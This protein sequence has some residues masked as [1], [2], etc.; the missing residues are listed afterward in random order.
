MKLSDIRNKKVLVKC[1]FNI[2]NLESLE[3]IEAAAATIGQLIAQKNRLILLTHW[4]RPNGVPDPEWSTRKLEP[5]VQK[6]LDRNSIPGMVCWIDQWKD[7]NTFTALKKS[8]T[9][10]PPDCVSLME[11]TRFSPAEESDVA[12]E[13]VAL[14][15]RYASIAD[16]VV[17][18]A[19]SLSH[20]QE[21]TNYDL[22]Q[23]LPTV[24][25]LNYERE[26]TML[27]QV[28]D[29]PHHPLVFVLGGAKLETKLELIGKA[30][31]KADRVLIGGQLCFT[32]LAAAQQLGLAQYRQVDI[33]GSLVEQSF[34]PQ[35]ISLLQQY[36]DKIV[37]PVDFV[38]DTEE[39]IGRYGA[40]IG[41]ETIVLFGRALSNAKTVFWN[42][43]MGR[44]EKQPYD[45]GTR[46][47]AGFL[48]EK[49]H[50]CFVCVGGGD[51]VAGLPPEMV[52]QFGFVSTGGG[53]S[54]T[55]LAQ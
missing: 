36:G 39:K 23:L 48:A 35:A 50:E 30:L 16:V 41:N 47:I 15:R 7:T 38:Y 8:L 34:I 22:E 12:A 19:F 27:S 4:G 42:G 40:D 17:D 9:L 21:A 28:R 43:P 13:R 26:I 51:T 54:L 32:F 55:F 20:R 18:E 29:T 1:D 11:N 45:A 44:L 52:S 10:L 46:S 2:P 37:L 53:A 6:V 49:R 31:L 5:L 33:A 3:R 14:A 24:R 25:G